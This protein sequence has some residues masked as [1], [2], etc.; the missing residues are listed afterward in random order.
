MAILEAGDGTLQKRLDAGRCP[1]CD[2]TLPPVNDM[3]CVQCWVCKLQI[4]GVKEM[5][6]DTPV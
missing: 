6:N 2:V 5:L 3:G 1:K 4:S